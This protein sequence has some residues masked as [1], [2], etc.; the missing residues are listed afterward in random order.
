MIIRVPFTGEILELDE[1]GQPL[2]GS[3]DNPVRIVDFQ[4][5]LPS[6]LTHFS[7]RVISYDVLAGEAIL[8]VTVEPRRVPTGK[9]LAVEGRSDLEPI[10]ETR[11]ETPAE[12]DDRKRRTEEA[13]VDLVERRKADLVALKSRPYIAQR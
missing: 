8:D 12:F 3:P 2:R 9:L 7:Y 10:P 5:L 13:L 6:E 1:Q 4:D 11:E